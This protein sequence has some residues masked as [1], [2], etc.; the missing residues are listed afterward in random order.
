MS[1]QA[2]ASKAQ[3][4]QDKTNKDLNS[5]AKKTTAEAMKDPTAKGFS[6]TSNYNEETT[7]PD[8]DYTKVTHIRED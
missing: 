2:D 6:T 3:N 1:A 5:N 7:K 8:S 4:V